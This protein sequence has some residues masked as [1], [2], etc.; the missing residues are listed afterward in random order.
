MLQS[1]SITIGAVYTFVM[2]R[3]YH[4]SFVLNQTKHKSPG[5]PQQ[6]DQGQAFL[7]ACE[8]LEE[9]DEEQRTVLELTCKVNKFLME[10]GSQPYDRQYYLKEKLK[11]HYGDSI[12]NT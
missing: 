2:V 4:A 10:D 3:I 7:Q 6:E 5:R 1:V 11:D 12:C 9:N 8:Y